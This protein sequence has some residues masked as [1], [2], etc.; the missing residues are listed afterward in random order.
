MKEKSTALT[1]VYNLRGR[2]HVCDDW[3]PWM[4]M[5]EIIFRDCKA[6]ENQWGESVKEK[7][8]GACI[9]VSVPK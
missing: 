8:R 4:C 1:G 9:H 3:I 5:Q 2:A 7:G 6:I